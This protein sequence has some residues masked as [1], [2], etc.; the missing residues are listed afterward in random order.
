MTISSGTYENIKASIEVLE[1]ILKNIHDLPLE[2]QV[3]LAARVRGL[4]KK[5]Q[6]LNDVVKDTIRW[7]FNWLELPLNKPFIAPGDMWQATLKVNEYHV[8]Q[9]SRLKAKLPGIHDK[10]STVVCRPRIMFEP[11]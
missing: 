8:F 4:R 9:T 5:T 1:D 3:E 2:E 7:R 10:Y 6:A 11:R